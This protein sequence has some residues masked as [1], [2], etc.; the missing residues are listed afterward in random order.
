MLCPGFLRFHVAPKTGTS[1]FRASCVWL[2][3]VMF[4]ALAMV[5]V[6]L[7]WPYMT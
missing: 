7:E 1:T 3:L 2:C 5:V 4:G 6:E